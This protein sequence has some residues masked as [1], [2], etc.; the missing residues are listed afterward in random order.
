MVI[1]Q[2]LVATYDV[3]AGQG[4]IIPPA[5]TSVV[6]NTGEARPPSTVMRRALSVRGAK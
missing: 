2:P 1:A 5:G 6:E 4:L 3:N